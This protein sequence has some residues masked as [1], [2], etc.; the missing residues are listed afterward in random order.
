[1]TRASIEGQRRK[2]NH[3]LLA[4]CV[5]ESGAPLSRSPSRIPSRIPAAARAMRSA[6]YL[7]A[8]CQALRLQLLWRFVRRATL[9]LITIDALY[10]VNHAR[11]AHWKRGRTTYTSSSGRAFLR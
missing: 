6:T 3:L 8:A 7:V 9:T 11:F 2:D 4:G 1:M 5:W 10:W